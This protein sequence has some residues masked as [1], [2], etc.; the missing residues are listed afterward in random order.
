V[1]YFKCVSCR[2]RVSDAGAGTTLTDGLCP[3]C[4]LPLEPVVKLTEV[5]GFR[6]PNLFDASV[7]PPV[8]ERVADI[9]GGRAAVEAQLETDRWLDEGGSSAPELLAEAVALAIPPVSSVDRRR[10]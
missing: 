6:S 3:A 1:P 10:T 2:V 4:G 7:P 5:L 8:A 9:S